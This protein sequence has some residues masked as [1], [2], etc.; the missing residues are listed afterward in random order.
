MFRVKKWVKFGSIGLAI[1][2]IAVLLAGFIPDG[3]VSISSKGQLSIGVNVALAANKPTTSKITGQAY[4]I[5]DEVIEKRTRNSKT[6][7]TETGYADRMSL[8]PIHYRDNKKDETEPWK[9]ID[10]NIEVATAPWNWQ[11][12]KD[13][14]YA[15][16][17]SDLT[18][19]MVVEVSS[20][21]EYVQFQPMALQWTNS[22]DQIQQ[23][24]MPV[25]VP[26]SVDGHF[27]RWINGYGTGRSIEWQCEPSQLIKRLRIDN[28]NSL[29][30][31]EQSI[32]DGG[33]PVLE[34]N[35]IFLW[36]SGVTPYVGGT[37]WDGKTQKETS[38]TVD[39]KNS[40]GETLFYFSTPT[41]YDFK[42]IGGTAT[43]RL[44]KQGNKFYVSIRV[45]Y[46]WLQNANYP[47]YIDPSTETLRPNA[48]GD[49]TQFTPYGATYNWQCVDEVTSDGNT[50]YVYATHGGYGAAAT[51]IDLY[52]LPDTS[53]TGTINSVT[54]YGVAKRFQTAGGSF[55]VALKTGGGVYYGGSNAVTSTWTS[56]SNAWTTNPQAGGAWTWT[57]INALQIGIKGTVG[58]YWDEVARDVSCTQVYVVVNYT[59]EPS[60]TVSPTSY[61]FGAV[62]AS[63]TPS[64][65][66][67]YFTITNASTIQTDQTIS[68]T[69]STWSGGVTWTHSDTATPGTNTAGLLANRGGTWGTGDVIVKYSSPNYIYENCP[70]STNYSFGLKLIAP[71]EF[72]DGVQKSIVVRITA[73]AG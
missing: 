48:A 47:V 54:V 62:A 6:F 9:D 15:K 65:T 43:E 23:V 58:E 29:P 69:T 34:L 8:G 33:N 42:S 57:Q 53:L 5:G 52:N 61:N 18:A 1:A 21:G 64:T 66:T 70:A 32:I 40:I 17:L 25:N 11:M 26:V 41:Y 28:F 38:G 22:L 24:S 13:D 51:W 71:T 10:D 59:A 14:Y 50:T 45:P 7:V 44:K 72:T 35:F 16:F 55:Y 39:F 12:V 36:S 27:I 73:V 46:N 63:S 3:R 67:T 30:A 2:V 20:E 68:V 56:Y 4:A 37:K 49:S 19:G 60:I 31:P